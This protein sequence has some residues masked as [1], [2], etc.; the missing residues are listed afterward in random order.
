M[1]QEIIEQIGDSL[2]IMSTHNMLRSTYIAKKLGINTTDLECLEVLLRLEK[3]TAGTLANE[4]RLTTGAVTKMID[5]LEKAGFAERILDKADRRKVFIAL[6]MPNVAAK[7]FPL[8][9]PI[10]MEVDNL[11]SNYTLDQ[12]DVISSFLKESI[13]ISSNDLCALAGD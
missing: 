12:L 5:R 8:Y 10:A 3:A 7:V 13:R 1:K 2:R 6:N 9:Q 11:L 4:T